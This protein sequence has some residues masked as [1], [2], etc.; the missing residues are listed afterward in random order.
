M[1]RNKNKQNNHPDA[2]LF[3]EDLS[4]IFQDE[5]RESRHFQNSNRIFTDETRGT[6]PS[7]ETQPGS[8]SYALKLKSIDRIFTDESRDTT[9]AKLL[10]ATPSESINEP[11][12]AEQLAAIEQI[13]TD[14]P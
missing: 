11:S 3:G 1:L 14:T 8:S 4:P 5:N 6:L 12:Y 2:R 9:T 7:S 10:E 13:F